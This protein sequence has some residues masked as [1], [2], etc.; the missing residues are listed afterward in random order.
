MPANDDKRLIDEI[1]RQHALPE[2][3]LGYRIELGTDSTG[4]PAAFIWF[5]VK[6]NF[7][8]SAVEQNEINRFASAISSEVIRKG[9]T[10]WPFV[11]FRAAA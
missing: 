7:E 4:D 5:E 3:V 10:H 6:K 1:V 8:P 2:G 11:R 9:V